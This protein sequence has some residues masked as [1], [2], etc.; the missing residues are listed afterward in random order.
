MLLNNNQDAG[1]MIQDARF[2]IQDSGCKIQYA[3]YW[4]SDSRKY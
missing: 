2:R 1:F 3:G 4:M